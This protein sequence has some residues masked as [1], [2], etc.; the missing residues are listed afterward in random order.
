MRKN[1]HSPTISRLSA[2][3]FVAAFFLFAAWAGWPAT[4]SAVELDNLAASSLLGGA[5]QDLG[6]AVVV[7]SGDSVYVAGQTYSAVAYA[8]T[9]YDPVHNGG[10]DGFIAKFNSDLTVLQAFTYFGGAGLDRVSAMVID[11]GGRVYVTGLTNSDAFPIVGGYDGTY[12]GGV[13][14]FV[15]RFDTSLT[16]LQAATFLGGANY[17]EGFGLILGNNQDIYWYGQSRSTDFPVP[18]GADPAANGG[19]DAVVAR[20]NRDLSALDAATYL[21]GSADDVALSGAIGPQGDLFLTGDTLSVNFPAQAGY[22]LTFNGSLDVFAA[23]LPG[24]LA[25][26]SA[27]TFLGGTG[28]EIG[29]A[30]AVDQAGNVYL[31][32]QTTGAAIFGHPAGY[33]P[34]YN[35]GVD[36]FVLKITGDLLQ[37]PAATYLGGSSMDIADRLLIDPSGQVY[38]AG[39]TSSPNFPTGNG[40]DSTANGGQDTFVSG[41]DSDL[42]N[43]LSSSYLGGW[44]T[45]GPRGLWSRETNDL[46]VAGYSRSSN[47]PTVTGNYDTTPNGDYDVFIS[48]LTT[49]SPPPPPPPPPAT[50]DGGGSSPQGGDEG[51]D[52]ASASLDPRVIVVSGPGEAT[53]LRVYGPHGDQVGAEI[54]NLF[55][56]NYRGGAGVVALDANHDGQKNEIAV[57][58]RQG[59]PQVRIFG[60]R[61]GGKLVLLGQMFV[62]DKNSRSGLRVTAGDF[63]NDGFVDDLA[64]T[65]GYDSVVR[66]YRDVRGMDNWER[67]GQFH[68][69][70]GGGQA[71]LGTFQY[72]D[73][74]DEILATPARGNDSP[75]V[76]VYTVGGTLK[77][78]FLAYEPSLR[79]GLTAVGAG[80]RIFTVPNDGTAQ[81]NVFDKLGRR[82]NSWW[83]FPTQIRGDFDI[84]P[85]DID[86]DGKDELLVAPY[87]NHGPHIRSFEASGR[88]RT[89]PNF[90][91]FS[92]STRSGVGMAVIQ[93]WY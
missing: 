22:D 48:R 4:S 57:F 51:G 38:V 32:G 16:Q 40:Y 79:H 24:D 91:A 35:G 5:A 29:N 69:M 56:Q 50:D 65:P 93:N 54:A 23:R 55:P 70:I 19:Q 63:D 60:V 28:Q 67:I 2:I 66:I 71:N 15:A 21:G 86:A 43:L 8:A 33:D 84:V 42:A 3:G 87:G 82:V 92:P 85:G 83:A 26:L 41:L 10:E 58:A 7:A 34:L 73:R 62:F 74:A 88:I 27:S 44:D 36:A 80:D 13:D 46:Y 53:K 11:D 89:F 25:S 49:V 52:A 31:A 6:Q 37:I 17:D 1:K 39:R 72:D 77:S 14:T 30:L 20:L 90:F 81:V 75:R 9:G 78:H 61:D 64:A 18:G 59:G 47:F 45:D 76:M 12:N 68:A